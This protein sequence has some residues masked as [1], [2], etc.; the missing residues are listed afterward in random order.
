MKFLVLSDNHGRWATVERIIKHHR[1]EVDYIFHCG[2]SEFDAED[3]VWHDVDAVV[4]GNMDMDSRYAEEQVVSTPVG[5][6]FLTHGHLYGVN[7]TNERVL[8]AAQQNGCRFAFHGH[9][10]RLYAEV[11]RGILLCNPG[12]VNHSRGIHPYRTY[13]IITI[14]GERVQVD[15]YDDQLQ[16]LDS[17]TEVFESVPLEGGQTL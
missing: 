3:M 1:S 15:F 2:D 11:D 16:R 12:S 6:V 5:K 10:H 4:T 8:A 14:A 9:T 7:S 13:A 17:L